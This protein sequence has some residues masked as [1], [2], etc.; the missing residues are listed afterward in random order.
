MHDMTS[1]LKKCQICPHRCQVDRTTGEVGVCRAGFFP[2]VALASLHHGEEPCIS[3][4]RGSGTIFFSHCNLRCVFCQ[5]FDISQEGFGKEI[6]IEELAEL[7]L[8]QERRGAHNINLVSATQYIPQV[9]EAILMARESGLQIPIVYNSNGYESVEAIR[10]MTGVIDVYLPD[11]KYYEDEYARKYSSAPCYFE[12]AT[13]VIQEMFRQVGA[14]RFDTEGMIQKGLI[15]RHML[16]PGHLEDSKF[17]L[18]WIEAHLPADVYVSLM[19]QY[20]PM[21]HA[22][23]YE[24]L[25]RR[26]TEAEYDELIDYFFAIGL[27]NGYIQ[28]LESA[29]SSYTPSF[30]LSGLEE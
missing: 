4:E 2:K 12:H 6:T 29:T 15:I 19:A 11:L 22:S 26:V 8:Q 3:G 30:D 10:S 24:E 5:N 27:D 7:M 17:V 25:T 16:L 9:K 13:Q 20:T 14:P 1:I 28:E 18:D 23:R 21:Y